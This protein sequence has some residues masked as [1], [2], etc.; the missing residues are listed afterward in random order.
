MEKWVQFSTALGGAYTVALVA[1]LLWRVRAAALVACIC[2]LLAVLASPC[3][4]SADAAALRFAAAV[5]AVEI[6]AKMVD[7]YRSNVLTRGEHSGYAG[8]LRC[9]NPLPVMMVTCARRGR[10]VA[11]GMSKTRELLRVVASL[12]AIWIGIELFFV[13]SLSELMRTSFAADHIAKVLCFI[14]LAD[15][16]A[17]LLRA[18]E[19]LAGYDVVPLVDF[20]SLARTPADFWRRYNRRV[21][22]WLYGFVFVPAGGRR[23]PARAVFIAFLA[24]G[25][26]HEYVFAVALWEVDGYQLAFFLLQGAG[27]VASRPLDT[28]T[29]RWG[30]LGKL[31]LRM[32]TILFLLATSVFFFASFAKAVPKFYSSPRLLP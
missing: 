7:Y 14:L 32:G 26:L 18:L 12:A 2:G 17:Q 19:R 13:F 24:N 31:L 6:A 11:T 10:R 16:F 20:A 4:I 15:S 23:H 27:V 8:Y 30:T 25:V 1:G 29:S 3:L 9:L 28:L 22:A 21:G 5:A